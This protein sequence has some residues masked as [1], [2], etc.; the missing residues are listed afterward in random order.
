[1]NEREIEAAKQHRNSVVRM[2]ITERGIRSAATLLL[3]MLGEVT[4]LDADAQATAIAD[5]SLMAMVLGG[6]KNG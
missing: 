2:E 6:P 4:A 1:M 3:E 5:V